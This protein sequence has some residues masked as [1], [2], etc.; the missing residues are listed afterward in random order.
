MDNR[1]TSKEFLRVFDRIRSKGDK[2]EHKYQLGQLQAWHDYD[3]YTCWLG[4]KD[5]T[6]TM[7]FHGSLKIDYDKPA[8]YNDFI[9]QC[10]TLTASRPS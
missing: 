8:N 4:Y 10:L 2:L 7:M 1:L 3:G 9:K 6:V 5:V